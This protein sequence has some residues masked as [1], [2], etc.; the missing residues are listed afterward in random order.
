ML[1]VT[2]LAVCA[3]PLI[4]LLPMIGSISVFDIAGG[5]FGPEV[6]SIPRIMT[7]LSCIALAAGAAIG[8]T[9]IARTSESRAARIWTFA[10]TIFGTGWVL[11][12]L[13]VL[14]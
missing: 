11:F 1:S 12:L 14:A 3:L 2:G 6:W 4:S 8:A 5:A 7:I 13:I 9:V 10:L